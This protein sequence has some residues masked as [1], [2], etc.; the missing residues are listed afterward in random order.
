MATWRHREGQVCL[1][2]P[3]AQYKGVDLDC[4]PVLY[5]HHQTHLSPDAYFPK[6]QGFVPVEDL[7]KPK[8]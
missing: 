1:V 6:G 4:L 2:Q 3:A 5:C 8:E 7:S